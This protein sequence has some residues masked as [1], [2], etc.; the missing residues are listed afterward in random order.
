MQKLHAALD[1][2]LGN[3][4]SAS[5]QVSAANGASGAR[6][7]IVTTQSSN[8]DTQVLANTTSQGAIRDADP[9]VA[10]TSL[11][12]QQTMLQAAQLAFS[13]ISQLGLFNKL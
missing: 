11:T 3:L 8:N 2:A 4:G 5:D 7:A 13:K 9:V 10:Y 1:S 12:L 6:Q